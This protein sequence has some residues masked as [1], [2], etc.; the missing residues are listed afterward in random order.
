MWFKRFVGKRV[1]KEWITTKE[2][3]T[4]L[5]IE[6]GITPEVAEEWWDCPERA[7]CMEIDG[8]RL[9]ALSLRKAVRKQQSL[10][11]EEDQLN[12]RVLGALAGKYAVDKVKMLM[13]MN[14]H[15]NDEVMKTEEELVELLEVFGLSRECVV[16]FPEKHPTYLNAVAQVLAQ[17]EFGSCKHCK[18]YKGVHKHEGSLMVDVTLLSG[19]VN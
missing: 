4:K 17:L 14:Q 6:E 3:F 8:G 16:D 10:D 11:K 15:N 9:N 13:W 19:R 18:Y 1:D 5:L 12:A 7:L 2:E